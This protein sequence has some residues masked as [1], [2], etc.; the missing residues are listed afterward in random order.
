[1]KPSRITLI[2]TILIMISGCG[3]WVK[4]FDKSDKRYDK[5]PLYLISVGNSK[6]EVVK[7]LGQPDNVIGSKQYEQ[8]VVEVWAYEKWHAQV[9]P[10][11][12]EEIYWLYFLDGTL[13]QWGRPGDWQKEADKIYEIRIR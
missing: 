10:D 9:G 6:T 2:F 5:I 13:K 11:Y 7:A 8:S 4:D 3:W 1:M 12:I